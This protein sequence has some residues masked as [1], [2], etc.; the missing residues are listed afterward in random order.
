MTCSLKPRLCA[1]LIR[2]CSTMQ[3]IISRN[4][5]SH[6]HDVDDVSGFI[7][8]CTSSFAS[9]VFLLPHA[10]VLVFVSLSVWMDVSAGSAAQHHR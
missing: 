6:V 2:P 7:Q 3:I 8:K 9:P 4:H 5:T 1:A 10:C